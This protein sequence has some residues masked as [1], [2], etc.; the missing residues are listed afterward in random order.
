MLQNVTLVPLQIIPVSAA[1]SSISWRTGC[2]SC[3]MRRTG[4]V[5]C[6]VWAARTAPGSLRSRFARVSGTA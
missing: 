4:C 3:R 6:R 5:S 1:M 2:V